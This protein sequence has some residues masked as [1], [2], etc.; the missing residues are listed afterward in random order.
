MNVSGVVPH[1]R[2]AGLAQSIRFYTTTLGLTVYFGER[3]TT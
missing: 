1:L 3:V 2:T